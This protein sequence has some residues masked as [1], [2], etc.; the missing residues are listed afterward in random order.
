MFVSVL[1]F[2]ELPDS[3]LS[4]PGGMVA[5]S[6]EDQEPL[7]DRMDT[8]QD[9][10]KI[11]VISL[12]VDDNNTT[13]EGKDSDSSD[14][15]ILSDHENDSCCLESCEKIFD[16]LD[17]AYEVRLAKF[18]TSD[19]E[20]K[21]GNRD[22]GEVDR[23]S[24]AEPLSTSFD[25]KK[26]MFVSADCWDVPEEGVS[27][28]QD[29]F[30]LS[31]VNASNIGG[32][33]VSLTESTGSFGS[34][35][36]P[37][38][39]L[40][41]SPS[42]RTLFSPDSESDTSENDVESHEKLGL[43]SYLAVESAKH[44][45]DPRTL[46]VTEPD[47]EFG[48][49]SSVKTPGDKVTLPITEPDAESVS[50]SSVKTPSIHPEIEPPA[51]IEPAVKSPSGLSY[52]NFFNGA[53]FRKSVVTLPR[54]Q[55]CRVRAISPIQYRGPVGEI[56]SDD[57]DEEEEEESNDCSDDT[58]DHLHK[59]SCGNVDG[60]SGMDEANGKDSEHLSASDN[61][62]VVESSTDVTG[63]SSERDK[64]YL[65]D[66]RTNRDPVNVM[67]SDIEMDDRGSGSDTDDA[68]S[69]VIE[70]SDTS[71]SAESSNEGVVEVVMIE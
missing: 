51:L 56:N 37:T 52:Q 67:L 3:A 44:P 58:F 4:G 5:L 69:A 65:S 26:Y 60:C 62:G 7:V 28:I 20:E 40:F 53:C 18:L 14:T 66:T 42:P 13:Y 6:V 33:C 29:Y 12:E 21:E 70:V 11:P 35:R 43:D 27:N 23:L 2:L 8:C 10:S 24:E 15:I 45:G 47:V 49:D 59:V 38:S 63:K 36:S 54:I 64:D 68:G 17:L 61:S 46:S 50:D 39:S 16:K 25:R 41:S 22:S 32:T 34:W 9:R 57:D 19:L 71:T 1:D 31:K 48:S 30:T 55:I